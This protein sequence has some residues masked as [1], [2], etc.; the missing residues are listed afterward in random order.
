MRTL[1]VPLE[2]LWS[3]DFTCGLLFSLLT[4]LSL[5][6]ECNDLF[7]IETQSVQRNSVGRILKLRLLSSG[8]E[9]A[10]IP[11]NYLFLHLY[12]F[13]IS[14]KSLTSFLVIHKLV[15]HNYKKNEKKEK[16]LYYVLTLSSDCCE[17]CPAPKTLFIQPF[18]ISFTLKAWGTG[19][20]TYLS[21]MDNTW[22]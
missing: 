1:Q 17:L 11:H 10:E 9:I 18:I 19:D 7:V 13:L 22:T 21:A 5:S 15:V 3:N 16:K 20:G 8:S 6:L 12:I 4:A 2:V 14:H